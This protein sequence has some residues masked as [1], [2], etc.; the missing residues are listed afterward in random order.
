MGW[1]AGTFATYFFSLPMKN[2]FPSLRCLALLL[3]ASLASL[4]SLAQTT[5]GV[6]IGAGTTAPDASAALEI[7]SSSKGLLLPRLSE[8]ARLAMG[9]GGV[10]APA[11][12]L[13]VYQTDGAAPGFYYNGGGA[14]GA[15]PPKWLRLTDAEGVSYSP[16]SG[17][18]VGPGPVRAGVAGTQVGGT[19]VGGIFGPFRGN[20]RSCRAEMLYPAAYLQSLGLRPG[21]LTALSYR[22]LQKSS[23]LPYDNFTVALGLTTASTVSATFSTGLTPVFAGSVTVPASGAVLTLAFNGS[24]F[25]WDG[26]SAV[27]VQTCYSNA[28]ASDFDQ[29]YGDFVTDSRLFASN[30]IDQCGATSGAVTDSRPAVAFAQP[31]QA[32]ALPPRAGLPGQVLT[33]QANGSV[34]FQSPAAPLWA[35]TSAGLF[36]T[37]LTTKVGVGTSTPLA[38]L[39]V[40]GGDPIRS[41]TPLNSTQT[42][43]R[44]HRPGSSNQSWGATAELALGSYAYNPSNFE[45]FSQLDIRLGDNVAGV[46]ANQT[47]LTLRGDGRLGLG[48]TTPNSRLQLAGSLSLPLRT[49]PQVA[50]AYQNVTVTDQDY[51]LRSGTASSGGAVFSFLLP[52]PAGRAGRVVVLINS[53][54]TPANLYVG[55]S[56]ASHLVYDDTYGSI[57]QVPA[58]SRYTLQCD[59]G[60]WLVIGQ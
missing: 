22:V 29:L 12:G 47:V 23:T 21:P 38:P 42:Q 7:A 54:F 33:Q 45:Q 51:T 53:G 13:L 44:L 43:L 50:G 5:G 3:A 55:P 2:Q 11:A 48:T 46:E 30:N 4:T 36:P 15:T 56:Y 28:A 20:S 35:Q 37:T 9:T 31:A 26:T 14:G 34:A 16:V 24:P 57:T 27:L 32:Y 52:D 18:Q 39:E 59:G 41:N 40:L 19:A 6:R 10:A 1:E 60:S 8:A 17:L 25:A 58:R 49:V